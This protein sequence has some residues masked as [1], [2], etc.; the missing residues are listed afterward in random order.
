MR[1]LKILLGILLFHISIN[2][3]AQ[4]VKI[5]WGSSFTKENGLNKD[6]TTIGTFRDKYFI[7]DYKL[8][9]Y[10]INAFD[11]TQK[12]ISR[13][14]TIYG[15]IYAPSRGDKVV[16]NSMQFVSNKN[17]FF[18]F[19]INSDEKQCKLFVT[20]LNSSFKFNEQDSLVY[21]YDLIDQDKYKNFFDSRFYLYNL[22]NAEGN[23]ILEPS[24]D[25]SLYVLYKYKSWYKITDNDEFS[26]VVFDSN[27]KI[28]REGTHKFEFEKCKEIQRL[29]IDNKGN[30]YVVYGPCLNYIP[31]KL[32]H[33]QKNDKH[34]YLILKID[35]NNVLNKYELNY[36]ENIPDMYNS[37]IF[38]DKNENIILT[39]I[40]FHPVNKWKSSPNTIFFKKWDKNFNLIGDKT[41]DLFDEKDMDGENQ[42]YFK[43]TNE[44]LKLTNAYFNESDGNIF[45]VIKD[46]DILETDLV[47][48]NNYLLY[49]SVNLNGERQYKNSINC[50]KTNS[51]YNSLLVY[52]NKAYYLLY[53]SEADSKYN[54]LGWGLPILTKIDNNGNIVKDYIL[55]FN[56][57]RFNFINPTNCRYLGNGSVMLIKDA[58]KGDSYKTGVLKLP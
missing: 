32:Y 43:G 44:S 12:L 6:P 18:K 17:G 53:T 45:Y 40:L 21:Q 30:I 22:Q 28:I 29:K 35:A 9:H 4:A 57:D 39:G 23:L 10:Y 49:L 11:T 48:S 38:I 7:A 26:Y 52:Y 36:E 56:Y 2:T 5:D 51:H 25:S 24:P 19:N 13:H 16:T 58:T 33:N 27:F 54:N 34:N 46:F 47:L 50:G 31:Y 41:I 1:F 37:K 3:F 42:I 20:K 15:G 8:H 55:D 14:E